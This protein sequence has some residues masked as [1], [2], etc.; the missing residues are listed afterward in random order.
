MVGFEAEDGMIMTQGGQ[1]GEEMGVL[2]GI[3]GEVK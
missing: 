3:A 1:N 2:E